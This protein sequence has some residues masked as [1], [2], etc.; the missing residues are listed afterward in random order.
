MNG[1]FEVD[2]GCSTSPYYEITSPLFDRI[3]LTLNR[4]YYPGEKFEIITRNNSEKNM[5][6]RKATLNGK[7]WNDCTFP[8]STFIQG[9]TLVLDMSSKPNKQWGA[10]TFER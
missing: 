9:G 4:D 3:T 7:A 10:H 5:Y 1:L 8:H 2:G 6:I